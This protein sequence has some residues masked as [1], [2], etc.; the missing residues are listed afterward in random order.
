MAT[1]ESIYQG[2]DIGGFTAIRRKLQDA[3]RHLHGF[4]EVSIWY[5]TALVCNDCGR[6]KVMSI[7]EYDQLRS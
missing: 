4:H 2:G 7:S 5:W 1:P 6:P 3:C